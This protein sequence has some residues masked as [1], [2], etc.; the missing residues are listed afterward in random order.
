MDAAKKQKLIKTLLI[1]LGVL[2]ITTLVTGLS[3]LTTA[4]AFARSDQIAR[5][6]TIAGVNV[7]GKS[8]ADA[9]ETL[10]ILWVPTLP[11]QIQLRYGQESVSMSPEELG[12]QLQLE[13]AAA[14]AYDIGRE[15]GALHKL[16]TLRTAI[17]NPKTLP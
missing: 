9:V 8:Q 13:Q 17:A 11:D 3:L 15:G 16:P 10:H 7:G 6:V 12:A 5:G 14:A 2:I 1:V 4:R